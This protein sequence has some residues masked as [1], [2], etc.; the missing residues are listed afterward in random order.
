MKSNY[1]R[2]KVLKTY[3]TFFCSQR[4]NK[5]YPPFYRPL[6][7][8][9]HLLKVV[10]PEFNAKYVEILWPRPNAQIIEKSAIFKFEYL[11]LKWR[12]FKHA[13]TKSI[14]ESYE[15]DTFALL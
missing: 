10:T 5:T 2:G 15:T 7:E 12:H 4:T 9:I 8:E 13:W 3:T 1:E 14:P 6:Q 11:L